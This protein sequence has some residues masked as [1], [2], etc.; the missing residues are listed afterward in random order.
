MRNAAR[1]F[2]L[3]CRH[4]LVAFA[5]LFL[6]VTFTPLTRWWAGLLAGQ[7]MGTQGDVLIV[8]GGSTL[9]DALGDSSYLRALY[10]VR[11]MRETRYRKVILCGDGSAT[12]IR[13]FIAGHGLPVTAIE[14]DQTSGST[15]ENAL[16]ASAILRKISP[17]PGSVVLLTSDYHI[18][19]AS[20]VFRK[21]GVEVRPHPVP[22]VLK[23]YNFRSRRWSGFLDLCE[24]Q[25]KTAYYTLRGWM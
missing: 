23:R 18:Y 16:E 20:R 8:L 9:A 10:A 22:D 25:V 13:D 14:L 4:A 5:L 17:P 21:A 19:R 7:W 24:E 3:L 15:R 12:F 11:A 1:R 6:V 2:W